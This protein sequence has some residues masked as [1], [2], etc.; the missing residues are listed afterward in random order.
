MSLD[1]IKIFDNKLKTKTFAN[2]METQFENDLKSENSLNII[3]NSYSNT[4]D[5]VK[6]K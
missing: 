3:E 4:T 1:G 5:F 6:P 2:N